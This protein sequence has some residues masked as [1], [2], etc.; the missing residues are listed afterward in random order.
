MAIPDYQS[1]MLPVL[2][3]SALGEVKVS[4]VV[5]RL[6]AKFALTSEEQSALLPSGRQTTFANRVHW[7]KT[8]LGQAGLIESTGRGRFRVTEEGKRILTTSPKRIDVKFLDRYPQFRAFRQT[9]QTEQDPEEASHLPPASNVELAPDEIM[10]AA[11]KRLESELGRELLSRIIAAPPAFFERLV[12]KLLTAMGYGG[13][14]A[15]TARA[16]GRSGDGGVDGVIDQDPLGLD[17]VYVQAKRYGENAVG[18]SAIR[19]FFGAL[20]QY[21]ATKGL[22][23]TTS[24]FSDAASRTAKDMSRRIVLIDGDELTRLMIQYGVGCRVEETLFV[25]KVDEEFFEE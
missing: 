15:N 2:E 18:P 25:K 19:D 1:L 23:L 4:N 12:I 3:Q 5:D 14:I 17:R 7:A 16:L 9:R 10:R 11:Q 6:A 8:Y 24:T 22:F 20:D 13:A 21:R